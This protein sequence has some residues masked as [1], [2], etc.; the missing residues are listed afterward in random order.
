M[1]HY[2]YASCMVRFLFLTMNTTIQQYETV[3]FF[4]YNREFW[5]SISS[6]ERC[7]MHHETDATNIIYTIKIIP[8][9]KD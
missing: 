4:M 6:V 1:Y 8:T 3:S 7:S 5:P 2:K 9:T